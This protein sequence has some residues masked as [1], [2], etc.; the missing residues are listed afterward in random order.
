MPS[1]WIFSLG[2]PQLSYKS[3]LFDKQEVVQITTRVHEGLSEKSYE[4]TAVALM[5]EAEGP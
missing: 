5:N 3:P 2:K 1:T 4:F